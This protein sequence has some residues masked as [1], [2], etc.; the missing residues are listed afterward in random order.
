ML[1]C[2]RCTL[3]FSGPQYS[4]CNYGGMFLL[5]PQGLLMNIKPEVCSVL[6]VC[7]REGKTGEQQQELHSP[8]VADDADSTHSTLSCSAQ[9]SEFSSSGASVSTKELELMTQLS[10]SS[11]EA[12]DCSNSRSSSCSPPAWMPVSCSV[13]NDEVQQQVGLQ[14]EAYVTMSSFYQIK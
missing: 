7:P 10:R 2:P 8:N 11:S 13:E 14:E 12:E 9:S 5:F 1:T 4:R 3:A 6:N